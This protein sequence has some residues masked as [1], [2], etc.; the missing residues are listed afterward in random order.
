MF[1][2]ICF[3]TP[4][5]SAFYLFALFIYLFYFF[6]ATIKELEKTQQLI[7]LESKQ[8]F[9]DKEVIPLFSLLLYSLSFSFLLPLSRSPLSLALSLSPLPFPS[10]LTTFHTD[11]IQCRDT[12]ARTPQIPI[13][14]GCEK[15]FH[16]C[17]TGSFFRCTSPPRILLR[18]TWF[19][20]KGKKIR[21]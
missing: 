2:Y 17:S 16:Q 14:W 15:P 18:G 3:G 21:A 9:K 1:V 8:S 6:T 20:Q 4:P 12:F 11:S 13:S 7:K 10:Y 19:R 5:S